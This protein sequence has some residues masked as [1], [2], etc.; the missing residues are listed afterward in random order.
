VYKQLATW[1]T[2]YGKS[3]EILLFPSDEFGGQELPTDEI[4][5]FLA[6]FKLTKDL[7]LTGGGCQLMDKVQV[8]GDGAHPVWK[9]AKE[10]FPGDIGWNF[11]GIFVFDKDGGCVGRFSA[12]E[13]KECGEQL[14]TLV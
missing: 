11:A 7:P 5:P 4:A 13:L 6:G 3:L 10:A 9:L 14:A 12:K 1:N 8:N 2:Q